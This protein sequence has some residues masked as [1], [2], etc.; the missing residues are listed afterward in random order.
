MEIVETD[1]VE[2]LRHRHAELEAQLRAEYG[3]AR[4]DDLTLKRL[5]LEKL[6]VK[7]RL[8]RVRIH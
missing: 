6:Y 4:P 8:D 1:A 2:A 7:E 5:K 3:R